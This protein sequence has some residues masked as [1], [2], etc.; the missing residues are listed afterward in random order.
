MQK[1]RRAS[2]ITALVALSS[3]PGYMSPLPFGSATFTNAYRRA[4]STQF[5]KTLHI[6][7]I[8]LI[9]LPI[10]LS[11]Q[12]SGNVTDK[13]NG[14]PIPYASV[15][16]KG[17]DIGATTNLNGLFKLNQVSQNTLLVI[18]AIGYET[19]Q[20]YS[21]EQMSIELMP[22]IYELA[23][24][25]VLPKKHK[26]KFTLNPLKKIKS[27][28][29]ISPAGDYPWILTKFFSHQPEFGSTSFINQIQ[30]LTLC[31]LDSATFNLG[32]IAAGPNGEP[33]VDLFTKNVIVSAR[34]GE[35]L[36]SIDLTDNNIKFPEQGLFIAYEWLTIQQNYYQNSQS[37]RSTNEPMIGILPDGNNNE[38]WMY[39]KGTWYKSKLYYNPSQTITGQ[40]AVQLTITK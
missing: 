27:R 31:H 34:K 16:V 15:F 29:F 38:I 2:L 13:S 22:K 35:K 1:P 26:E 10:K 4:V 8:L 39:S 32:L 30:I 21:Q 6:I 7:S 12:I 3:L 25:K 11:G 19:Q 9:L 5:M 23:E 17:K 40:L 33:S 14:S 36:T 24:I 20:V 28:S 37:P 18:S